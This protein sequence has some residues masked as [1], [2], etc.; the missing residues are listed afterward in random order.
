FANDPVYEDIRSEAILSALQ[1]LELAK[2]K[3]YGIPG[4][5]YKAARWSAL[6]HYRNTHKVTRIPASVKVPLES[7]IGTESEPGTPDFSS[8]VI[9]QIVVRDLLMHGLSKN[10]RRALWRHYI[11]GQSYQEAAV[12]EGISE[13][14]FKSR[15]CKAQAKL[16]LLIEREMSE[17]GV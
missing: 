16:R 9:N 10:Q 7:I 6:T 5:V 13:S 3:G 8:R 2:N 17:A 1:G 15:M 4:T 11:W 12:C 14:A